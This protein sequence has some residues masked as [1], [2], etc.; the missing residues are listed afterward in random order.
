MCSLVATEIPS[1]TSIAACRQIMR[2]TLQSANG[3]DARV[4][5]AC[6]SRFDL[7]AWQPPKSVVASGVLL[8]PA[9]ALAVIRSSGL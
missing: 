4:A 6:R 1:P 2:V 7:E 8:A 5:P 3:A 9:E